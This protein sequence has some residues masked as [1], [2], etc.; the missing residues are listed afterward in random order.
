MKNVKPRKAKLAAFAD[1]ITSGAVPVDEATATL[2]ESSEETHEG[3]PVTAAA[4]PEPA[5]E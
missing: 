1:E 3:A 2:I 4:L 5:R